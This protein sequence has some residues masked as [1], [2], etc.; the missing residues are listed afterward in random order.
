MVE[1][2]SRQRGAI[3]LMLDPLFGGIFWGK[4]LSVAGVWL[5]SVVAAIVVFEATRSA[6]AVGLVSIAQFAPQL[7]LTPTSGTWA[8]RGHAWGQ[9]VAG[10]VLCTIG[11]GFL[12][13]WMVVVGPLDGWAGAWPVLGAS[14]VLGIGFVIG[15]PAQ[16]SVIPRLV[17]VEELP[18]AMTL[19]TVPMTVAR[20]AGPAV[21]ALAAVQFGW[22]AAFA[23]ATATQ[24]VFTAILLAIRFP[25]GEPWSATNDYSVRA[26]VGHVWRHRPL[27]V[28]LVGV[29]AAGM[30]SEPTITL[31]PALAHDL[32]GGAGLVG[33]LS[34]AFGVGAAIGLFTVGVGRRRWSL[35]TVS[36][37]GIALL[38]AGMALAAAAVWTPAA[39]TGFAVAGLGFSWSM[40][41]LSTLVQTGAPAILRGRIMALWMVAFVGSRPV[42]ASMLGVIADATSV[43]IALVSMSLIL[44]LIALAC[45][46]ARL[47]LAP[48]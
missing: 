10:R 22:A 20:V 31:A 5:H 40:S 44:A 2:G 19:N 34:S 12:T 4:L 15:G 36:S 43:R 42:A 3:G 47:A 14:L 21:G 18:T 28:A 38:T 39:I 41:S 37:A 35:P 13:A 27:L 8:D 48:A 23:M 11:S 33:V 24:L 6:F 30:G 25:P 7:L 16:Q 1:Q 46:P 9:M 32:G 26:A 17:T 45:R 29:T